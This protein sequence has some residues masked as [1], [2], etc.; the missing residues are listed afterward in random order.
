M[1]SSEDRF[2]SSS[3]D[4]WIH[5]AR[6]GT[7]TDDGVT[8]LAQTLAES[9]ARL[10]SRDRSADLASTGGPG[11][12]STIWGPAALVATGS[13]VAKL[14]V[15]GRPAGGIDVLMQIEGYR[16]DLDERAAEKVLD[17]CGYVHLLAGT[18]FAPMDAAMFAYRQQNGAQHIPS[19]AIASLLSKKLATG[20]INAGLEVRVGPH[21]NFGTDHRAAVENAERYCRVA[22]LLGLRGVCFVTDGQHLQQPYLG[23]GEALLALSLL[24]DGAE[25]NWLSQHVND[26]ERWCEML[27]G[28]TRAS[29]LA[30]VQTI[31]DN[32]SAQGGDVNFLKRRARTVLSGHRSTVTASAGGIVEYNPGALRQAIMAARRP[33]TAGAFDDS[34]G[35]ILAAR[36]GSKVDQ[37]QPLITVRCEDALRDKLIRDVE[38]AI[39]VRQIGSVGELANTAVV[40]VIGV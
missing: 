7:L 28:R 17:R 21:G 1:V 27:V 4:S 31:I 39:S 14:G 16:C 23:R 15:P 20:T 10:E 33:D 5:H 35:L 18:R 37:G 36:P 13:S 29:R 19:L 40:E 8:R 3:F 24:L 12:I 25:C 26:C 6:T 38:D 11:S 32:I 2:S 30:V 9:G 34:A 22:G